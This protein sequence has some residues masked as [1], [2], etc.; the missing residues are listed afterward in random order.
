MYSVS[1][2][3]LVFMAAVVD[4]CHKKKKYIS[5]THFLLMILKYLTFI[6]CDS[7]WVEGVSSWNGIFILLWFAPTGLSTW[8]TSCPPKAYLLFVSQV[9]VCLDTQWFACRVL[10]KISHSTNNVTIVISIILSLILIQK[11]RI[12]NSQWFHNLF[13][14]CKCSDWVSFDCASLWDWVTCHCD[15]CSS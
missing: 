15:R 13:Y 7:W 6:R 5:V 9:R 1:T 14:D 8:Q 12:S 11:V 10:I 3:T 2:L 4:V